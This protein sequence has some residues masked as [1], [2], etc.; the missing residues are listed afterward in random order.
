MYKGQEF[1][2]LEGLSVYTEYG[3]IRWKYRPGEIVQ[4][5]RLEYETPLDGEITK[6]A[7]SSEG[8]GS[9][10][11]PLYYIQTGDKKYDGWYFEDKF[12]YSDYRPNLDQIHEN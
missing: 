8:N 3:L 10:Y 5:G 11:A 4:I 7:W 1:K 6:T 12:L 9:G 2:D